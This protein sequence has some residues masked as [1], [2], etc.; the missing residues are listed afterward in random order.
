MEQCRERNPMEKIEPN[1]KGGYY[2]KA[3]IIQEK[4]ISK[5]PPHIREVWDYLLREANHKDNK[6][7]P[8]TVKRG[9]LFRTY[10]EIRDGLCWY[11]GWRKM[12]Y[13]ENQM[14][15][16]MNF[17][18]THRCITTTKQPGGTLITILNYSYYQ[19]PKNYEATNETTNE[20]TKPQPTKTPT[21][22]VITMNDKERKNVK[23]RNKD[24]YVR[25]ISYLNSKTGKHFR[26]TS[27]ETQKLINARLNAKFTEQDFL[28][29]IDNK[30]SK[31]FTDP[32]YCEYLRPETLFGPKFESY[33]QDIPH[34]L[35]GKVSNRTI[36][37]IQ[38][39]EDWEPV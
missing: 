37:N 34:P 30:V 7:G 4:K 12:M 15:A 28:T 38:N 27:K 14:K 24:I 10:Q 31:W 21:P 13:S 29:V 23:E 17:L 20:N 19:D 18:R 25:I 33:L 36:Q 11:A 1:I 2:L 16:S 26:H 6:Y 9:Q 8:Y 39:M 3:R 5:A 32:K 22:T 35:Q